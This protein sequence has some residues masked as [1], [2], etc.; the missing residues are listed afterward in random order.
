MRRIPG[1]VYIKQQ[2]DNLFN[3]IKGI[4]VKINKIIFKLY[5]IKYRKEIRSAIIFDY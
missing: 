5:K 1:K 4:D 2:A 3:P